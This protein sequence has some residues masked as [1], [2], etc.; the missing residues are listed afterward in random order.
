MPRRKKTSRIPL[1]E[2]ICSTPGCGRH[3]H[4]Q[5][6]GAGGVTYLC[7]AVCGMERG[8]LHLPRCNAYESHA[9]HHGFPRPHRTA[10]RCG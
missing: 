1:E 2:Y 10:E 9:Q 7:C 3:A 5:C 6:I 8:T 4:G